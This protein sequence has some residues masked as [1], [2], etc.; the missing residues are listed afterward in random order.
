MPGRAKRLDVLAHVRISPNFF[1][2]P[3]KI[4]DSYSTVVLFTARAGLYLS[5]GLLRL[6]E[7]QPVVKHLKMRKSIRQTV[8]IT[9][10]MIG[11]VN[12]GVI[13]KLNASLGQP[14][15]DAI[16]R[17]MQNCSKMCVESE[18]GEIF[19]LKDRLKASMHNITYLLKRNRLLESEIKTGLEAQQKLKSE[20]FT[21]H[22][23][24]R[25]AETDYEIARAHEADLKNRLEAGEIR[26]IL[27]LSQLK[28]L[29]HSNTKRQL[30]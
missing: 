19:K 21:V 26:E 3:A 8:L 16:P 9:G 2:P 23:R 11:T 5:L 14:C 28:Q 10:L 17:V 27:L 13:F 1:K 29:N 18:T 12:L 6:T 24:Y 30:L 4:L 15:P 22:A 25:S 20:L 7:T